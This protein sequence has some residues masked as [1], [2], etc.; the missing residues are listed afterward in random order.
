MAFN[1]ELKARGLS[2]ADQYIPRSPFRYEPKVTLGSCE[3]QAGV[4][5][6]MHTYIND[7]FVRSNVVIGRYCSI[8][9]NVIIG[10][11][12]HEMGFLSTSSF[13]N[14]PPNTGSSI[15]LAD[16]KKRIRVIIGHDVWVGDRAIILSGV[17][18]G[19]GA[20]IAAG[21]IVTKDVADYSV[22]AGVPAK[23]LKWR[24]EDESVRDRLC[25]VRWHEFD[26]EKLKALDISNIHEVLDTL[27]SWPDEWRT[28]KNNRHVLL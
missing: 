8:G 25:R 20:V 23:P 18:V 5:V 17:S 21:S 28:M 19:N 12:H 11:G 24:F 10:S 1:K 15:K 26:P 4:S 7:G 9:R 3:I 22:V 13:F 16:Y 6:G 14:A 27:E 2:V